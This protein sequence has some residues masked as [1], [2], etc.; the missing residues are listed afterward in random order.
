[1]ATWLALANE[2][3]GSKSWCGTHRV[4]FPTHPQPHGGGRWQDGT[5]VTGL[6]PEEGPLSKKESRCVRSKDLGVVCYS[7]VRGLCRLTAVHNVSSMVLGK[8]VVGKY[9][10]SPETLTPGEKKGWENN[11]E[12]AD[13]HSWMVNPASGELKNKKSGERCFFPVKLEGKRWGNPLLHI[14]L[15]SDL[16]LTMVYPIYSE[17]MELFTC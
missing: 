6:I 3:W 5:S 10:L 8:M 16:Y 17:G 1:M 13:S 15:Q 7:S 14:R 4:P 2:T 9:A 11:Y 12:V